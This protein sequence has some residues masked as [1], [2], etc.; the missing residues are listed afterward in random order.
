MSDNV[1]NTIIEISEIKSE[2]V[3]STIAPT[4]TKRIRKKKGEVK[5]TNV[6]IIENK[7]DT[8]ANSENNIENSIVNEALTATDPDTNADNTIVKEEKVHK[9]RGRKPKGGKIIINNNA[10]VADTVHEYNII[11]HLKC[12]EHDLVHNNFLSSINYD[13][14]VHVVETF[15]FENSKDLNYQIINNEND[16]ENEKDN[17][18]NINNINNNNNT[19][20]GVIDFNNKGNNNNN[21]NT[22]IKSNKNN[23]IKSNEPEEFDY[24]KHLW[25]KIKELTINLHKNN[26]QD[27]KSDCFWCTCPF[28]NPPLYIPKYE[29]NNIYYCYGCFCSPECATAFLFKETIDTSTRFE[30]YHLLNHIYCKIYNYTKNIKPA[31]DPYY[32]LNKYYGNLTIQEYRLLLKNERILIVVDKPLSRIL[33]ELHEDNDDFINN[34]K[35]GSSSS[36]KFHIKKKTNKSDGLSHA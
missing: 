23:M 30:R 12:G 22:I 35:V 3:N 34:M 29:L 18:K 19:F 8:D 27:K 5:A 4:V 2:Q 13:P 20:I 31:P 11:L 1:E 25:K 28:D 33:P 10:Q 15:Q 26:I 17:S 24:T 14:T 21:N 9:K 7:P 16:N 36:T 6:V 32:T